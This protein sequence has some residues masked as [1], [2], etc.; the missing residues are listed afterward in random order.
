M[1]IILA[2]AVA[3]EIKF[4]E[5]FLPLYGYTVYSWYTFSLLAMSIKEVMV[6][7]V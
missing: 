2:S 1:E 4:R 6:I 5:F 3:N 7:W